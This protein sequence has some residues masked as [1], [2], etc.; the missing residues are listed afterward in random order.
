MWCTQCHTS[1]SWDSGKIINGTVHNPHFYEWVRRNE[2]IRRTPGD[3]PCGGVI[4]LYELKSIMFGI[5]SSEQTVIYEMHRDALD[6]QHEQI[7]VYR[8]NPLTNNMDLRIRFLTDIIDEE[9]FRFTLQK[10]EKKK[11][12]YR[13][14]HDV[15]EMYLFAIVDMFNNLKA[16][17]EKVYPTFVNEVTVLREFSN[18]HLCK[19]SK[20]YGCVVPVIG[21]EDINS[22]KY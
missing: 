21:N 15:L 18:N 6:I 7:P 5:K 4:S 13:E 22:K 19:I 10:R 2:Q 14:I 16:D 11:A 9:T 8:S 3:I 20:R 12:L 17:L 1:F